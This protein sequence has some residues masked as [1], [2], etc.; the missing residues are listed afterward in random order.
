MTSEVRTTV[1]EKIINKMS[2][3]KIEEAPI[4]EVKNEEIK[5]EENK[6]SDEVE[7]E[8]PADNSDKKTDTEKDEFGN[9]VV[10][11]KVYTEDEVNELMRQR[12][13]RNKR[14]E[15]Q[16]QSQSQVQPQTEQEVDE[17]WEQQ[18]EGFVENTVKKLTLKEQQKV[19]ET[20]EKAMQSEFEDKM[21]RGMGKYK[22]FQDVVSKMPIS[23]P[24]LLATRQMKDPAAF[25]YAAS[26]TQ[27]KELERIAQIPDPYYQAAEMGRLEERMRKVRAGTGSPKPVS[28]VAGDVENKS[29]IRPSVDDLIRKDAVKKFGRR[30]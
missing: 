15:S 27:A 12:F 17:N 18:L 20:R 23:D 5:P 4:E 1:D 30:F 16:Q 22:D 9:E 14:E 13:N 2:D 24:M 3:T 7:Y 21:V 10:K 8:I 11:K 26:K 28:Q 6:V 29:Y 19:Q 25:I